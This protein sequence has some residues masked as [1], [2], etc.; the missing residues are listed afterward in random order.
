MS[1]VFCPLE[2]DY[3][4][5]YS[6]GECDDIII[7]IVTLNFLNTFFYPKNT[8]KDQM[9]LCFSSTLPTLQCCKQ[10]S[11]VFCPLDPCSRGECDNLF[12]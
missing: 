8:F 5:P 2:P 3:F 11:Q 7:I 12:L 10:M 9:I 6:R 4:C 1:Q